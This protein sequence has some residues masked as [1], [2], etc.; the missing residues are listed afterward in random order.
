MG[1]HDESNNKSLY[2]I[3]IALQGTSIFLGFIMVALIAIAA[4]LGKALL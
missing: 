2:R 4:I 3:A 1:Y